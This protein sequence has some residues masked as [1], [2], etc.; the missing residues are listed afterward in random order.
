MSH[1]SLE[2]GGCLGYEDLH[3]EK[4]RR[5]PPPDRVHVDIVI[6]SPDSSLAETVRV[7]VVRK[8][9]RGDDNQEFG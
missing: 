1:K 5:P 6:D 8:G 2:L 3:L 7:L 4:S 9:E